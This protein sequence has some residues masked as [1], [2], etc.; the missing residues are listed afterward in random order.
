MFLSP[1]LQ[2]G[3]EMPSVYRKAREEFAS[4][5]SHALFRTLKLGV[6]TNWATMGFNPRRGCSEKGKGACEGR[7]RVLREKPSS[8]CT[9]FQKV[10]WDKKAKTEWALGPLKK[11]DYGHRTKRDTE[12]GEA[13]GTSRSKLLFGLI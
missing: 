4:P 2:P 9:L 10:L 8:Q 7:M 6:R 1:L 12:L 3:S 11:Q 13:V 5:H